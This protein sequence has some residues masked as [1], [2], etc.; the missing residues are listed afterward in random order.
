M[1]AP[2]NGDLIRIAL[3]RT[4][5][6]DFEKFAMRFLSAILGTQFIPQ[7][8]MHDGGADGIF[9]E[10]IYQSA[11][12][13][14]A[15]AQASIEADVKSKIRNTA[16]RLR[17]FGRDPK[18]LIYVT[19]QVVSTIDKVEEELAIGLDLTVRIYDGEYI[20]N[21]VPNDR[22]T[23]AAYQEHLHSY[24]AF[25]QNVSWSNVL[26][27]STHITD[28]HV[29]TYLS[30]QLETDSS[31][32]TFVDGIVDAM[33]VYALEGTDP[34]EGILRTED[35]IYDKIME[36]LPQAEA[37]LTSKLRERLEA[38]S[39][40]ASRRIRWHKSDDLWAL[41]YDD[42][43]KLH[44]ASIEDEALRI[45]TRQELSSQFAGLEPEP[46]L[47]PND[48]AKLTLD[49]IQ[50]TFE[51][52]GLR[53]AR[54]LEG[55]DQ[56]I[57]VPF[58]SDALREILD[59]NSLVGEQRYEASE[60]INKVLRHIFYSSTPIQRTFMHR[61]SR[62]Y[63]ICFALQ[64]EPRVLKY[65]DDMI[66]QTW[67][68]V[69][70]DV[71]VTALSER[72]V[73]REDQHTRNLLR[74]V[75]EAGAQLILTEP[76]LNELHG[77]LK[78]TDEE[79]R[80]YVQSVESHITYEMA[81][82]APKILIRAYL[83][84]RV[85]G[86]DN[87]PKSWEQ[88]I[89]QF[90]DYPNLYKPEGFRQLQ[91]YL[92]NEFGLRFENMSAIS[93]ISDPERHNEL[94]GALAGVKPTDFLASNDAYMYELVTHYRNSRPEERESSEYGH[95][96][97]WLSAGEGAA[98]RAMSQIDNLSERILMRPGFLSKYIQF[99]PSAADARRNLS[100]FLPSLLGIRL[101]RRV[102][103]EDYHKLIEMVQEAESLEGGRRAAQMADVA[104]RLKSARNY[105]Y[106]D[107]FDTN[108]E[109]LSVDSFYLTDSL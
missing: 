31:E 108:S 97:W 75:Q 69:G 77:H 39:V 6:D 87:G 13:P 70:A 27:P 29:Y 35:E 8:G 61:I 32:S 10:E 93:A 21:H 42:R 22:T 90:C 17:N 73:P 53:F 26:S 47:D 74:V 34:N 54:Y 52:D 33:I 51:K 30:G 28:P 7:G 2:P 24:T 40:K 72:Y 79:Y 4:N 80:A 96:T 41:P 14:S 57:N 3:D 20:I 43:L 83:Y 64:M 56:D 5:G 62:A 78:G 38:I 94:Q 85:F 11:S 71:L 89:N 98:V 9:R 84:T 44:E 58:V 60:V 45:K 103:E 68:Y 76:V 1:T 19:N 107:R 23:V 48:L 86:I 81:R 102:T 50:R 65:F 82:N 55:N 59:E 100:D 91:I 101:A 18:Q 105:E 25:L 88:Y 49:T 67:L 37:L 16:K 99:A 36:V 66:N 106:Q 12:R 63:V 92:V 109:A 46:S 15:F 104:D 95:R